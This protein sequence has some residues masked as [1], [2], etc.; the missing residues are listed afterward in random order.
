M[1]IK[2]AHA[3]CHHSRVAPRPWS[4]HLSQPLSAGCDTAGT[5]SLINLAPSH[6]PSTPTETPAAHGGGLARATLPAFDGTYHRHVWRAWQRIERKCHLWWV[7]LSK[8][9]SRA[10]LH[11][12]RQNVKHFLYLSLKYFLT[13]PVS[14]THFFSN[15]RFSKMWKCPVHIHPNVKNYFL[16][17]LSIHVFFLESNPCFLHQINYR[18]SLL[19]ITGMLLYISIMFLQYTL[20]FIF[21]NA[22]F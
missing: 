8:K 4:G 5:L 3:L 19:N 11:V 15:L 6:P 7:F 1:W 13:V 12:F 9:P 2:H 22:T 18:K 21:I 20:H 10:V 16:F 17:F 14:L